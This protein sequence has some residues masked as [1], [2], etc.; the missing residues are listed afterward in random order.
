MKAE[1]ATLPTR[2]THRGTA[3][4]PKR[5]PRRRW[6]KAIAVV[7]ALFLAGAVLVAR[8]FPY[9]QG[10][11]TESLRE[12]LPRALKVEHFKA[13]YFPH[14]GCEMEGLT[15]RSNS[16]KP[17]SEPIVTV[18][19]LTIVGSYP[20]L[21]L[22]PHH[23][24]RMVLE[25]LRVHITQVG[26]DGN[27]GGG[28]SKSKITISEVIANGAVLEVARADSRTPLRFE[29][30]QLS[31]GSVGTNEALTYRVDMQN[32]DPP[33]EIRS[34][35]SFGPFN[36][37]N[38]SQTPLSGTYSFDRADLG[39]FRGV[40]GILSSRGSFSGNLAQINAE[41]AT[42]TPDFEVV[43]SGHAA[44]LS[45]RFQVGI[46]AMNGNVL[47]NRVDALYV[48]T[49]IGVNGSVT[50]K[51]DYHAKFTALDFAVR[52]GRIQDMLR[53]FVSEPEPPM[54]GVVSFQAHVAVAPEGRPFLKEV[55]LDGDFGI[56][57][58]HFEKPETQA[59]AD[60][61]SATSRGDKKTV[62]AQE[63]NPDVPQENVIS[64]LRGHVS[65]RGGVATFSDLSFKV[66]GADARMNGTYNL[67]TEAVNFHGTLKMDTK[68]SKSASG[69]KSVFAKIIGPF[70][71]KKGGSEVPVVMNGTYKH[72][73]FGLD[74]NPAK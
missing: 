36:S 72:P 56:G 5:P 14:P 55:T 71:T 10:M 66:P 16:S 17:D 30:H 11:V 27:F 4:D 29:I 68:F 34:K 46:D 54:A 70:V 42:D 48:K 44:H 60:D 38:P 62:Q 26:H 40:A 13:V 9:S 7:G 64:D 35:G 12:P 51:D 21:L 6:L 69:I 33:G 31:L 39:A 73:H 28:F 23:I 43:R 1:S 37:Q 3:P 24:T 2:S 25:G 67:L 61:L 22:R 59:K 41:G 18:S 57:G 19:K 8:Y 63:Q 32:S 65:L 52:E 49:E 58:G 45:T 50:K 20:N 53:L 15:F 47:L 74:L